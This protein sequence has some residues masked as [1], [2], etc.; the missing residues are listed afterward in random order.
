MKN[1]CRIDIYEVD[2]KLSIFADIPDDME[3]TIAGALA[4]ALMGQ[5]NG[6]MNTLLE[7]NQRVEK[8][9]RQ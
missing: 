7:D 4:H 5:A 6:I 1:R 8:I 3:K 2:G 9:V